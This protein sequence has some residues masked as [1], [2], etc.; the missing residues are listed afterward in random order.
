MSNWTYIR[1]LRLG[2][3]D[4]IC[5][6]ADHPF[7]TFRHLTSFRIPRYSSI[8]MDVIF[9]I[10]QCAPL[11]EELQ[12]TATYA[13]FEPDAEVKLLHLPRL[14]KLHVIG[15]NEL[16]D[17]EPGVR[18]GDVVNIFNRLTSPALEYLN[19][20]AGN[21]LNRERVLESMIRLLERST[22]SLLVLILQ[23]GSAPIDLLLRTL[24]LSPRLER[25]SFSS[26]FFSPEH[27][28]RS[29]TVSPVAPEG[30]LCPSLHT[31]TLH[32]SSIR[33]RDEYHFA[34]TTFSFSSRSGKLQ[35]CFR[36]RSLS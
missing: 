17:P 15:F 21:V 26:Y 2:L 19:L 4:Q 32:K 35:P 13:D 18:Q 1:R 14:R 23:I 5:R 3:G 36:H 25:F 29:L 33:R 24:A 12:I 28:L 11:L 31:L 6:L 30:V 9:K 20:S 22:A 34:A 7:P 16:L 10:L 27:L 8:S